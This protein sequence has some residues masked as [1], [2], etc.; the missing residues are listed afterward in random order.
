MDGDIVIGGPPESL[1]A[2]DAGQVAELFVITAFG[3]FEHEG[4]IPF[5]ETGDRGHYQRFPVGGELA[6]PLRVL[7]VVQAKDAFA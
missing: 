3:Y 6:F 1:S 5:L 7:G 4:V 2:Q